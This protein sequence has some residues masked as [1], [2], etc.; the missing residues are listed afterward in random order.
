[1]SVGGFHSCWLS[2]LCESIVSASF[3]EIPYYPVI[4][5]QWVRK[6]HQ[7]SVQSFLRSHWPIS[8][9]YIHVRISERFLGLPAAFSTT[10]PES[11]DKLSVEDYC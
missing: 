9:V 7:I 2:K 11:R 3:Y 4:V 5:K 6:P 10:D 8:P 1:M